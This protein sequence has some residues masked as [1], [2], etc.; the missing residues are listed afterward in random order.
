MLIQKFEEHVF[1]HPQTIAVKTMDTVFTYEELNQY[2]N[3]IANTIIQSWPAVQEIET[4]ALLFDHGA[5]MIA[6]MLGVLKA[7]KV[8]VPLSPDYP[9]N[10]ISYML[11]NAGITLIL[12]DTANEA[13][14]TAA[15]AEKQIPCLNIHQLPHTTPA[16]LSN[17]ER[18]IKT[19]QLAYILFTSGSTGHPKGVMQTH[20]NIF[21][22]IRNWLETLAI[23]SADRLTLFSSFCHDGA[24]QDIFAAL[25]SGATLYPYNLRNRRNANEP[26]AHFLLQEQITIWHSVPSLYRYFIN[27]LTAKER[28]PLIRYFL[29]G[30]EPI[31]EHDIDMFEK[32]FP[33]STLANIYGQTESSV[34]SIWKIQAQDPF[35]KVIIGK[36]LDCT[37]VFLVTDQGQAAEPLETGEIVVASPHLSVGYWQND[38]ATQAVFTHDPE[39]G[40]M[41]WTGDLGKLLV[42]GSIEFIGRRDFQVKIRGFRVELGEIETQLLKHPGI[43]EAIVAAKKDPEGDWYLVAYFIKA[44]P[45]QSEPTGL[46]LRDYLASEVPDYMIPAHFVPMASFPLTASNKI[47]RNALPEPIDGPSENYTAPRNETEEKVVTIWSE[48]LGVNK[49]II[50]ISDSFFQHGGHSLKA[51][52]M[53]NKIQKVFGVTISL[54]EVFNHLTITGIAQVIQNCQVTSFK[55]IEK[56]PQKEYYELSY[57]QKR[58]WYISQIEPDNPVLNMTGR[59]TLLEAFDE[60]A[61]QYTLQQLVIRHESLRTTFKEINKEPVLLIHPQDQFSIAPTIIDLTH[62][63]PEEQKKARIRLYAEE[64]VYLFNLAETLIKIKILKC[65]AN[66]FDLIFNM[67]HLISDGWSLEVLKNEFQVFYEA[68][69]NHVPAPIKPLTLQYK[70]YAAWQN[71]LLA[72]ETQVGQ[73]LEFWREQLSGS[74]PPLNLPYDFSRTAISKASAGYRWVLPGELYQSLRVMAESHRASLFMVLLAGFNLML[75][76]V[77]GQKEIVMAIPAA[78]RRHEALQNIIGIFVNILILKNHVNQDESFLQFFHRLQDNTFKVLDYQDIPM[79]MICGQ[80]KIKY[81]EISAYFN[82]I[83]IATTRPGILHN[84]ENTHIESVQNAKFDIVCYLR[85]YENAIDFNCHYYKDRFTPQT[86]EKLMELYKKILTDI[87]INPTKTISEYFATGKKKKL[88]RAGNS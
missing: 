64:S 10:R 26:V 28:F 21:Y 81:P 3:R 48:V 69:K 13:I 72:D 35:R 14:A 30:G 84:L 32:Y 77:S 63:S 74:L 52:S 61:V 45:E 15:A 22:Y 43:K 29:L 51:I 27:S 83:N 60:T 25:L 57:S 49:E 20:E 36:P 73:A 56:Q 31:R 38:Q 5:Y 65:Q 76:Q 50:G 9:L 42:D 8:Y 33:G 86:I 70:D 78:A 79:E 67:H 2:A 46:H 82:M 54:Q 87:S 75:A 4:V 1:T 88:L 39:L 53:I 62:L 85:E 41:Y 80:L 7:N 66:E 44:N 11:K 59:I 40:A 34:T 23:T 24:V 18:S 71:Q 16:A 17:P 55:E 68:Y 19:N 12:T 47:D 37:Q 6:A 58:L